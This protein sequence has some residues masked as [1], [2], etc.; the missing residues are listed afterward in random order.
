V[1]DASVLLEDLETDFLQD[2]WWVRVTADDPSLL[3]TQMMMCS[4]GH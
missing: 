1:G 2:V 3:S 4:A